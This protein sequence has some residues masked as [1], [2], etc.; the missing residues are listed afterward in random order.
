MAILTAPLSYRL[1]MQVLDVDL[2]APMSDAAF[3]QVHRA[4][5]DSGGLLLFPG[6]AICREQHIAFSRRFGELDAYDAVP[7]GRHP[8]LHEILIVA[9]EQVVENQNNDRYLGQNWHS[10]LASSL[11]PA[12]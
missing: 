5:L 10:D 1:G 7:L 2:G 12:G 11:R 4:F 3:G 9:N 8:Q 6:Q